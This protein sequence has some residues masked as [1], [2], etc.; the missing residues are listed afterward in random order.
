[1]ETLYIKTFDIQNLYT[2]EFQNE[3]KINSKN[4]NY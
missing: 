4:K 3:I 2:D 1:M